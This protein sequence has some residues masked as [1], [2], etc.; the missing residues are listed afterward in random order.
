[1]PS[2]GGCGSGVAHVLYYYVLRIP[3]REDSRASLFPWIERSP[4]RKAAAIAVAIL[5]G[6]AVIGG[7][8]F[9]S[10]Q[11][12]DLTSRIRPADFPA[13]PEAAEVVV[14]TLDVELV[15]VTEPPE[16]IEC[17]GYVR[18]FGLPTNEIRAAWEYRERPAPTL[19]YRIAQKGWFTDIDGVARIRLPVR[20]LR[21]ITVRVGRGNI[22]IVDATG[23]R[24][25][26][27]HLPTLDLYTG[28]GRVERP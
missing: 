21:R 8:I 18:G 5:L 6:T 27:V 26:A 11:H 13:A 4:R 10:P 2:G 16:E 20:N 19:V 3:A 15:L 14:D 17:T 22:R 28:D 12:A 9:A 7:G 23:G 24:L 1:M 25:G